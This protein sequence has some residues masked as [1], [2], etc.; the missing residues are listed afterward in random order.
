MTKKG[1][2]AAGLTIGLIAGSCVSAFAAE[3]LKYIQASINDTFKFQVNGEEKTLDGEYTVLVYKDR[4]YLPVRG[5]GEL[6]GADI[7]WDDATKTILIDTSKLAGD[8]DTEKPDTPDTG[9][10]EET[11]VEY[12]AL[13][14]SYEN[15]DFRIIMTSYSTNVGEDK[16]S[17]VYFRIVNKNDHVVRILPANIAITAD[18]KEYPKY[19]TDVYFY[20]QD[21]KLYTQYLNKDEELNSYVVLPDDA[22]NATKI[23]LSIPVAV[24]DYRGQQVQ[25]VEFN[26]DTE[27]K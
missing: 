1:W 4:T 3:G 6:M 11:K 23:K 9:T 10:D 8:N 13:P 21:N 27:A 14:L 12:K 24:E 20:Y 25:N 18:G 15:D 7:D 2:M 16:L 17:K 5:I 19:S 22:K 26:I